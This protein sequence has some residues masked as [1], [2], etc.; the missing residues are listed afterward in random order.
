MYDYNELYANCDKIL[1][2]LV[3]HNG[4]ASRS[5]LTSVIQSN[6]T[7]HSALQHLIDD[8]CIKE[9]PEGTR[10]YDIVNLGTQI[11]ANGGYKEEFNRK[12]LADEI[13]NKI[14]QSIID[15]NASVDKTNKSVRDTNYWI[16]RSS[17]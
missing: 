14:D 12:R 17:M 13:K 8:G 7:I 16:K 2:Y 4:R 15:T 9:F 11:Q 1:N 6:P 5:E 3:A 10:N